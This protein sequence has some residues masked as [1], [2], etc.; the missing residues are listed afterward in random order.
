M[1]RRLC[2]LLGATLAVLFAGQNAAAA[3][4]FSRDT[5]SGLVDLR[6][7]AFW[8][9]KRTASVA[10]NRAQSRLIMV[11]M[12]FAV[13]PLPGGLVPEKDQKFL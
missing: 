13:S 8:P 7:A 5:V 3:E 2:A 12:L 6:A 9:A 4:L 11:S 1:I 10:P